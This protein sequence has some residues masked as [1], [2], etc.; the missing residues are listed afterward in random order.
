MPV[1]RI[2]KSVVNFSFGSRVF[3]MTRFLDCSFPV[4]IPLISSIE[5]EVSAHD[6]EHAL[7]YP[8]DP[9]AGRYSVL[10]LMTPFLSVKEIY[11]L[12]LNKSDA[13]MLTSGLSLRFDRSQKNQNAV[14][15]KQGSAIVPSA[16]YEGFESGCI[17]G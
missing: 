4:L 5:K 16:L 10:G 14:F 7:H 2:K 17:C 8:I 15:N 6:K 1:S 9:S 13:Q 3:L 11:R 12:D